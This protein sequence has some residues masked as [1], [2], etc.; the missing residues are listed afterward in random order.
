MTEF[1]CP[2]DM[3]K[4]TYLDTVDASVNQVVGTC[5]YAMVQG[6]LGPSNGGFRKCQGIQQRAAFNYQFPRT[7]VQIVDGLSN[8]FFV[9]ETQDNDT[10]NGHNVWMVGNRFCDT[11][12]STEAALNTPTGVAD[13]ADGNAL[14]GGLN[15]AFGSKHPSGANFTF[16]DAHV[17]FISQSIDMPT[18]RALSTVAG[19]E[20]VVV[21][22]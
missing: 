22:Q 12:R 18:Y 20:V 1:A 6:T 17:V 8:T 10:D 9:G 5:S 21:P 3:S 15:G 2:D 19:S 7:V 14:D 16:G 4:P 11:M 13:T